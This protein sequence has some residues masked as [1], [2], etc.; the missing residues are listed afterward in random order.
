LVETQWQHIAEFIV[1]DTI[2]PDAEYERKQP[3]LWRTAAS[4]SS[5]ILVA[6]IL[7]FGV[8]PLCALLYAIPHLTGPAAAGCTTAAFGYLLVLWFVITRV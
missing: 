3:W 7:L 1:N 5:A 2:P 4:F 8:A 6:V